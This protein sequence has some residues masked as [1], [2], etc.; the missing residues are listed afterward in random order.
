MV[1]SIGFIFNV[2]GVAFIAAA[3]G[4]CVY[5]GLHYI[6]FF[7]GRASNWIAPCVVGMLQGIIVGTMFMSMFSFASDT[8]LQCFMVDEGLNR[9]DGNRPAIMNQFIDGM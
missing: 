1:N 4:L 6:P 8:I 3:N 2:L 9:G 7:A 5:A